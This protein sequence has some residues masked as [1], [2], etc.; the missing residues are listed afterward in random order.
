MFMLYR[1]FNYIEEHLIWLEVYA[2]FDMIG[3]HL[4]SLEYPVYY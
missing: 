1:M 2:A 4:S 3:N